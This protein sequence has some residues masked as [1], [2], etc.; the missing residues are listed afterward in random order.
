MI[1]NV[2]KFD[3]YFPY[4]VIGVMALYALV[5]AVYIKYD[6]QKTDF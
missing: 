4:F 5:M 1:E 2:T 3:Y 6:Q